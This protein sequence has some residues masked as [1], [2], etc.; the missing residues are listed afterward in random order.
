MRPNLGLLSWPLAPPQSRHAGMRKVTPPVAHR[1]DMHP[2]NHADLLGP[3]PFQC[4]QD[5]PRPVRLAAMLRFRQGAQRGLFRG[6]SRQLRFSRH[7]WPPQS[8]SQENNPFHRPFTGGLLRIE[9][10]RMRRLQTCLIA[11]LFSP[12]SAVPLAA[13]D[14]IAR[15]VLQPGI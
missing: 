10:L 13:S 6:I 4:Q 8:S 1:T 2:E 12:F 3:P 14:E 15:L 7:L 11:G 5:R 9:W